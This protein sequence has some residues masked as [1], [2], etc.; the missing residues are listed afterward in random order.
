MR[1][2]VHKPEDRYEETITSLFYS[3]VSGLIRAYTSNR[4]IN[5]MTRLNNIE[6]LHTVIDQCVDRLEKEEA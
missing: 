3:G 2:A 6:A 4:D 1:S 5:I